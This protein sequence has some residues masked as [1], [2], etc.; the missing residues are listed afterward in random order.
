MLQRPTHDEP[1]RIDALRRYRAMNQGLD[2]RYD[3]IVTLAC[4]LFDVPYAALSLIDEHRQCFK[5]TVGLGGSEAP[6]SISICSHMIERAEPMVL[7]DARDDPRFAENPFV[8][9]GPF[10]RFYAGTPI[11]TSD[12]YAVGALCIADS[13]P[14]DGF[15]QSEAALLKELGELAMEQL[16]LRRA[17]LKAAAAAA[18]VEA[19]SSAMI[20]VDHAGEITFANRPAL[21]LLGYEECDLLGQSVEIIVPDR[22]KSAHRAGMKRVVNGGPSS[23]SGKPFELMARRSDGSELP[24]EMTLS[25]FSTD[26]GMGFGATMIDI[27]ERRARDA[28]LHRL[29]NFDPMTGLQ[30]RTS[31]TEKLNGLVQEMVDVTVLLIDLQGFKQV[32]D[33]YGH[34]AGD[35]ILQAFSIR[36]TASQPSDAVIARF[37]GDE[38]AVLLPGRIDPDFARIQAENLQRALAEPFTLDG[39]EVRIGA[40]IGYA[41][42]PRGS[43]EAD[44]LIANADFALYDAKAASSQPM[45]RSFDPSM[46]AAANAKLALQKELRR[47]FEG[48]EF[49]LHYQP[50]IDL[51]TGRIKGVEALIRWNHPTRGLLAPAEFLGVLEA[52]SLAQAVGWW[53]L[54]EACAQLGRW[55]ARGLDD[56]RMSVNLFSIQLR[57]DTLGIRVLNALSHN[58]LIPSLLELE[59]TETIAIDQ[60]ERALGAIQCLRDAGV[61]IA[62]DDFGT[63]FASLSSLKRFPITTLKIDRSFVRDS[64]QDDETGAILE[65]TIRL[66]KRLGLETIAEGVET[67]EQEER[68]KRMGCD[69]GQGYFYSRPVSADQIFERF[70]A[71]MTR[72][73]GP[74]DRAA[75]VL[76]VVA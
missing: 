33:T 32:N 11:T 16:E 73:Q 64:G 5:A 56:L 39:K 13:A 70:A 61:R 53:T 27:T 58:A 25:I 31:F 17:S 63:G 26:E 69:I 49:V 57:S 19:G 29:A 3:K 48:G 42:G 62:F 43:V 68:I 66:G 72:V 51:T 76:G 21:D 41:F 59:I 20:C 46:R 67:K 15:S 38:F 10:I 35:G 24:I 2:A 7:L 8:T 71:P 28:R 50:Q 47:A 36:L 75:A 52:M 54:E 74:D 9:A 45:L 12:G 22:M 18:F 60:E 4:R 23:L 55:R 65:A 6:R 34:A 37:G 14:R 40:G 30:N 44:E 1:A